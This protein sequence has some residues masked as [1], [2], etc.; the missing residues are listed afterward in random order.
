M[1][2]PRGR[3]LDSS[4]DAAEAHPFLHAWDLKRV[5][6]DRE[7]AR[8]RGLHRHT[9]RSSKLPELEFELLT[10]KGTIEVAACWVDRRLLQAQARAPLGIRLYVSFLVEALGELSARD[11]GPVGNLL[12]VSYEHFQA[13]DALMKAFPFVPRDGVGAANEVLLGRRVEASA[14]FALNTATLVVRNDPSGRLYLGVATHNAAFDLGSILF[15]PPVRYKGDR[16]GVAGW[17]TPDLEETSFGQRFGAELDRAA[18]PEGRIARRYYSLARIPSTVKVQVLTEP[19]RGLAGVLLRVEMAWLEAGDASYFKGLD[20]LAAFI[21]EGVGPKPDIELRNAVGGFLGVSKDDEDL[22]EVL[23]RS[24]PFVRVGQTGDAIAVFLGESPRAELVFDGHR[25]GLV[26]AEAD[27]EWLECLFF[28]KDMAGLIGP[29][30][31]A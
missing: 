20:L 2:T 10:S 4:V 28:H 1:S 17:K 13:F 23:R 8:L 7:D 29:P 9:Y 25:V 26:V 6:E 27:D 5:Q 14:S 16:S 31:T 3:I 24:L 15:S 18:A 19:T 30:A 11:Q 22:L 21:A 12:A